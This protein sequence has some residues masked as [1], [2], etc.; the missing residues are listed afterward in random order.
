VHA[1]QASAGIHAT[2]HFPPLHESPVGRRLDPDR[3]CPASTRLAASLVRLPLFDA[4][5]E[6]QQ[7]RVVDAVV[8]APL[9]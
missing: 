2:S 4:L 8:A 1:H 9:G 3:R 6:D 5:D 7:A